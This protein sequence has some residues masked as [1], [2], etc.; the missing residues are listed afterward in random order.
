MHRT[1]LFLISVSTTS[2]A[3]VSRSAVP[4][5]VSLDALTDWLPPAVPV[6]SPAPALLAR[7]RQENGPVYWLFGTHHK[8]GTHLARWL[9]R[10]QSEA[11]G[12]PLGEWWPQ[13]F[14]S[15]SRHDPGPSRTWVLCHMSGPE[16]KEVVRAASRAGGRLRMV[17]IIREPISMVVSSYLYHSRQAD[18]WG[19]YVPRV[20]YSQMS[21]AAG[22]EREAVWA[23]STEVLDMVSASRAREDDA[24]FVRLEDFTQSSASFNATVARMYEY[25]LG[26]FNEVGLIPDLVRAASAQDLHRARSASRPDE[27]HVTAA[28]LTAQA[29]EA[30]GSIPP[31]LLQQLRSAG[32]ALGYRY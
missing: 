28:E 20:N 26:G 15:K 1:W 11:I 6:D 23:L 25:T 3:L 18:D 16:V 30:V 13:G 29:K 8:T 27:G 21:L 2:F 32:E 9:A 14:C 7:S 10:Y 24:M 12:N 5:D 22:L 31:H 4:D 19:P 17:H